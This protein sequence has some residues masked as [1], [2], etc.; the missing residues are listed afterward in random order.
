M[1]WWQWAVVRNFKQL[2]KNGDRLDE[3]DFG[4][5]W[6][7]EKIFV[8]RVNYSTLSRQKYVLL[9][10]SLWTPPM[11]TLCPPCAHPTPV[12]FLWFLTV[13]FWSLIIHSQNAFLRL[14]LVC[15]LMKGEQSYRYDLAPSICAF[16]SASTGAFHLDHKI[17]EI[18]LGN[19]ELKTD[20]II[21]SPGHKNK[22][23]VC[24]SVLR[25]IRWQVCD[26][27]CVYVTSECVHAPAGVLKW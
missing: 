1:Y 7:M 8:K 12:W 3:L 17:Q 15:M 24:I 22:S 19:Y 9:L 16:P 23:C 21:G 4:S 20:C 11:P 18:R 25:M 27:V 26:S 5:R 6:Q 10:P 14:S 13:R 2:S